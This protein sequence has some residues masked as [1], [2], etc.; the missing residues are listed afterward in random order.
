MVN[1]GTVSTQ[2]TSAK[3]S[4]RKIVRTSS[5][6]LVLFS[7]QDSGTYKYLYY[8]IS[9]NDGVTWSSSWIPVFTDSTVSDG[10]YYSVAIDSS[11]NIHVAV[12]S[13]YVKLTYQGSDSWS[14]GSPVSVGTGSYY[15]VILVQTN[16]TLWIISTSGSSALYLHK[17]T[18]GTSWT[19]YTKSGTYTIYDTAG[20]VASNDAEIWCFTRN[21]RYITLYKFAIASSTWDSGTNIVT[22]VKPTTDSTRSELGLLKVA[23][24]EIYIATVIDSTGIRVLRYNGTS[25]N[26][27]GDITSDDTDHTPCLAKAK[28]YIVVTWNDYYYDDIYFKY[29]DGS[30]WSSEKQVTDDGSIPRDYLATLLESSD[31]YTF[32]TYWLRGSGSPYTIEFEKVD[33]LEHTQQTIQSDVYFQAEGVQSTINSDVNFILRYTKQLLSDVRF[34]PPHTQQ[35]IQSASYTKVTEEKV[36]GSSVYIVLSRSQSSILSDVQ[37]KAP[38]TATIDS[39]VYIS[40]TGTS[41]SINSDVVF[42]YF[43]EFNM[44]AKVAGEAYTDFNMQFTVNQ[45]TPTNP[46]NLTATDLKTGDSIELTWTDTGN[47]GYNIYKDV[48]GNWEK[49]NETVVSSTSYIAG[50]LTANVT[51]TFQVRGVNGLGTE[52][53]GVSVTGTP[54]FDQATYTK[55]PVW[56]IYINGV[57]QTDAILER[58]ELVYGP[59][60]S[61]AYFYIPKDPRTVGLP[62]ANRQTVQIYINNRLVFTGYLI[63]RTDTYQA[64]DL[65]VSYVAYS[66]LWKYTWSSIGK[67]F[68]DPI[69]DPQTTYDQSISLR[70]VLARAGCVTS[71]APDR[72]LYN[73]IDA[74]EATPLDLMNEL[75]R[76]MGNYKL[77]CSPSGQVSWYHVGHP[78]TSRRYEIGKHIIEETLTTDISN[79][80]TEVTIYSENTENVDAIFFDFDVFPGVVPQWWVDYLH[81]QGMSDTVINEYQFFTGDSSFITTP[82]YIYR[83]SNDS[84]VFSFTIYGK[85]ISDVEVYAYTNDKP[86]VTEYASIQATPADVGLTKWEDGGTE[87]R[88]AITAYREFLPT[89]RPVSAQ[90]S[91]SRDR[92]SATITLTGIPV[93]YETRVKKYTYRYFDSETRTEKQVDVWFMGKPMMWPADLAI[94][95]VH[96]G[97]K[98]Y[99]RLTT[100]EQGLIRIKRE[101][102]SARSG[103]ALGYS[104]ARHYRST[105]S[106][107]DLNSYLTE[108][109]Q[110]ELDRYGTNKISGSITVLGDETLDLRTKVNGLEVVRVVHDFS[111]GFLTHIDLTNERFYRGVAILKQT[112]LSRTK[113]RILFNASRVIRLV[114]NVDQYKYISGDPGKK[115]PEPPKSGLGILGD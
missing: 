31:D 50:D 23:D 60:F 70:S 37:F 89:W 1:L 65:R 43:V 115:E 18:N 93:R 36:I 19:T 17:S 67:V 21:Y 32:Y 99:K 91:I 2:Y 87:G 108:R 81:K 16:G 14:V 111:N 74:M 29:Y 28:D 104:F 102:V 103:R 106:I 53:S 86:V 78:V 45:P 11:D 15:P 80:V 49:L 4:Q 64:T 27:I 54:T 42:P 3:G 101:S 26:S 61:T 33:L 13:Y 76:Y 98:Y 94:V 59:S 44:Q 10:R 63:R 85:E 22:N 9:T 95:Y 57:E 83:D 69:E 88:F 55:K 105:T 114:T 96:K 90:V 92:N 39:E 8:K 47:Y 20:C 113:Q 51:Y 84:F 24:N 46:T 82:S 30:N 62:T 107:S 52:S 5:G 58:V 97:R 79:K 77:Y 12:K 6:T 48:G 35:T 72:T 25:W 40:G 68:N 73:V 41:S 109:A 71:G 112:R 34:N 66:K 38:I 110:A 56:K 100:G 75:V 7:L